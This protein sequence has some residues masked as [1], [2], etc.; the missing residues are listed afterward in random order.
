MIFERSSLKPEKGSLVRLRVEAFSATS[1]RDGL[2]ESWRAATQEDKDRWLES[3]QD[4]HGR[5]GF[6]ETPLPPKVVKIMLHPDRVYRVL[7]HRAEDFGR[8]SPGPCA[9]LA[10]VKILCT[11]TGEETYVRRDF[12]EVIS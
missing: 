6:T 3:T 5:R 12:L 1:Q 8:R 7:R 9:G 4:Y 10:Q 2:F 11:H